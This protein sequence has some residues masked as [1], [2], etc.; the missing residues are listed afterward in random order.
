MQYQIPF[1]K[2]ALTC[3][4]NTSDKNDILKIKYSPHYKVQYASY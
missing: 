1:H 2:V 3:N 4:P